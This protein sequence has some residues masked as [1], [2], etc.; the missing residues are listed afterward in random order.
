MCQKF[1]L[2]GQECHQTWKK[3]KWK[4]VY[5]T[6]SACYK[7]PSFIP[8]KQISHRKDGPSQVSTPSGYSRG[9]I[10]S[11]TLGKVSVG[12]AMTPT[13]LRCSPPKRRHKAKKKPRKK[14]KVT[15]LKI[16]NCAQRGT[17][18]LSRKSANI[19]LTIQQQQSVSKDMS[20]LTALRRIM[21][22]STTSVTSV[23]SVGHLEKID[24]Y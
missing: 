14:L 1:C 12:S 10:E 13:R 22:T 3:G 17:I 6:S 21:V 5:N 18:V 19:W 20:V 11:S 24:K 9:S 15:Q 23:R 2:H 7:L 16:E 4:P 8:R